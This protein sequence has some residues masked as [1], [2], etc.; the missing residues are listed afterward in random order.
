M[1]LITCPDC[2]AQISDA[3]SACPMCNR[4]MENVLAAQR[5][6]VFARSLLVLIIS[7][8]VLYFLY[9]KACAVAAGR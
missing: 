6:G 8:A 1:P 3:A 2:S 9:L 4:P 5:R 7:S